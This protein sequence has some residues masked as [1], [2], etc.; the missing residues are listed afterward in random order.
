MA[1]LLA[2]LPRPPW[3]VFAGDLT[4]VQ[5]AAVIQHAALHGCGDTGTLHLAAMTSTPTVAWFWPNPGRHE[6]VPVGE[7]FRVVAG[8]NE[9][10]ATFLGDIQTEALLQ[11]AQAALA[12][13]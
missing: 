6:W 3:R 5:L 2:R 4:L 8:R 7:K 10:P 9:P 13:R 12:A 1:D 11:A